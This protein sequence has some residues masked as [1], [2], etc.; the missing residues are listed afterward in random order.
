MILRLLSRAFAV[1]WLALPEVILPVGCEPE[2]I[3]GSSLIV[4]LHK[5][6]MALALVHRGDL[7]SDGP[8]AL[9]P[10]SEFLNRA[11][12]SLGPHASAERLSGGVFLLT[13][14]E[15]CRQAWETPIPADW[16]AAS[17]PVAPPLAD[18][19]HAQTSATISFGFDSG[20]VR[21][22]NHPVPCI[23]EVPTLGGVIREILEQRRELVA[24]VR[25]EGSADSVSEIAVRFRLRWAR[26]EHEP[27]C[28]TVW[29]VRSEV[30]EFPA[31]ST[32][33]EFQELAAD[34]MTGPPEEVAIARRAINVARVGLPWNRAEEESNELAR[35]R[36]A[37]TLWEWIQLPAPSAEDE[38]TSTALRWIEASS[39][40]FT[41]EDCA[42]AVRFCANATEYDRALDWVD[43]A[44]DRAEGSILSREA[45]GK[46]W[47][48][49]LRG[50]HIAAINSEATREAA[51]AGELDGLART[52]RSGGPASVDAMRQTVAAIRAARQTP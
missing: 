9:E 5:A 36:M 45:D 12:A 2:V 24:D 3:E 30:P 22:Q 26:P 23:P 25:V 46:A 13:Q 38:R 1:V 52:V 49:L 34:L 18:L 6:P 14:D 8:I 47:R 50:L 33:S 11:S 27:H 40:D 44:L 29:L 42:E 10:S 17:I 39:A 7:S 41:F 21:W 16:A 43:R 15:L 35:A 32:V 20:G 31:F 19:L 48:N 4:R 37:M 51:R 28:R